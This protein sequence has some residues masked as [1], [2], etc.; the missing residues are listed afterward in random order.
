MARRRN[1]RLID[2]NLGSAAAGRYA[3]L[4]ANK[5]TARIERQAAPLMREALREALAAAM[6]ETGGKAPSR[7]GSGLRA[8]QRGARAFG[9]RFSQLRG[10]I[11]APS[12]MVAHNEGATITPVKGEWLAVPLPAAQKA[13]GSPKLPG[14][15][16]WKMHG[17][18]I[19]KS[20][21]TGKLL[22]VR[23]EKGSDTLIF[24]YVLVPSVTL[25]S[26]VG[27][28]DRAWSQQ[29]PALM[30]AWDSIVASF[31]TVDMVEEA[32]V[33]GLNGG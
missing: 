2:T 17:S 16:S 12:Y 30:A 21:K 27:W 6:L 23:K 14:P 29:I 9:T 8:A 33:N 22:I 1:A 31:L 25:R 10:H 13:D 32:Y 20:P 3:G 18:F 26:H 24:L 7:S 15:N 28:A 11:L 19:W 4:G 5:I